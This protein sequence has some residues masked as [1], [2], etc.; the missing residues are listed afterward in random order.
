MGI[1]VGIGVGHGQTSKR[2]NSYFEI[3]V[4]LVFGATV[5]GKKLLL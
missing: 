5:K 4:S 1:G 2:N 3:C